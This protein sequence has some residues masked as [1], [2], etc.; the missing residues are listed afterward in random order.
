M[1][2]SSYSAPG[3]PSLIVIGSKKVDAAEVARQ[4][5]VMVARS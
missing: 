2:F 4:A 5:S 3:A 1:N